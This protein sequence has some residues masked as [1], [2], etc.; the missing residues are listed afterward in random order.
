MAAKNKPTIPCD[1]WNTTTFSPEVEKSFIWVLEKFKEGYPSLEKGGWLSTIF[2]LPGP[3][4]CVTK[5][6]LEFHLFRSATLVL[7]CL[8]KNVR[9]NPSIEFV[10]VHPKGSNWSPNFEKSETSSAGIL[11]SWTWKGGT[12][13]GGFSHLPR[14]W[15]ENDLHSILVKIKMSS[16][17]NTVVG[18]TDQISPVYLHQSLSWEHTSKM[19]PVLLQT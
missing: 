9:A 6:Q 10:Q 13:W 17:E 19:H 2:T 8:S 14:G 12:N 11:R 18:T 4:E 5:W 1:S 7:K 3:E 16:I 15:I